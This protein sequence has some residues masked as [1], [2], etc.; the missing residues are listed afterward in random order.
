[1]LEAVVI[2]I[3][4]L[5][6][7]EEALRLPRAQEFEGILAYM[8]G[9]GFMPFLLGVVLIGLAI[10]LVLRERRQRRASGGSR[11]PSLGERIRAGRSAIGTYAGIVGILLFYVLMLGRMPFHWLTLL[12]FLLFYG[13]NY[14]E[15]L[16]S[17][18]GLVQVGA[19]AAAATTFVA[20]VMP[21]LLNMPLP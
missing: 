4:G 5:V 7:I 1:M 6:A 8:I 14:A 17:I 3:I 19:L 16:R 15:R 13:F 10:A 12:F 11:G 21:M 20:Y 2:A 9:P 18:R